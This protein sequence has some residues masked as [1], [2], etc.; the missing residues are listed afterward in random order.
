M[1]GVVLSGLDVLIQ[2][3]LTCQMQYISLP[4]QNVSLWHEDYFMLIISKNRRL[5]EV[6][7]FF[8]LMSPL[9]ALKNLD[10]EPA[11]GREL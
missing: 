11:S 6:F 9:A 8:F 1:S 4:P 2:G 7:F 10:R 5:G 3:I